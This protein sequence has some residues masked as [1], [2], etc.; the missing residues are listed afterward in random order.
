[1]NGGTEC[2]GPARETQ[3][4]YVSIVIIIIIMIVMIVMMIT[5]IKI[6]TMETQPCYVSISTYI[7]PHCYDV[8]VEDKYRENQQS[9]YEGP[10][11]ML[12]F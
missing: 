1:M 5:I 7:D 4:C 6:I 9:Y 2:Q 11:S 10:F 8:V 12:P 3:P